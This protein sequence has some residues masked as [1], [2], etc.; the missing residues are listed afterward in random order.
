MPKGKPAGMR[1]IQLDAA[2]RCR[3]F[4]RPERPAVCSQLK[5]SSEMC[6]DSGAQ[7]MHF[8]TRLERDT[9]PA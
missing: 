5:P 4:G 3:V 9:Q 2:N 8:L 7:A 6:G 1:C